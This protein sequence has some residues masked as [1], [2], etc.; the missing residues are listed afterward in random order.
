MQKFYLDPNIQEVKSYVGESVIFL[1][2]TA[3]AWYSN[4]YDNIIYHANDFNASYLYE[5][6]FYNGYLKFI[7]NNPNF[8][9]SIVAHN[10]RPLDPYLISR[11][12]SIFGNDS[13]IIRIFQRDLYPAYSTT[14]LKPIISNSKEWL[15]LVNETNLATPSEDQF[16]YF[17]IS[18]S[19]SAGI[20]EHDYEPGS[21][22]SYLGSPTS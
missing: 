7:P 13:A 11:V 14:F 20:T 12:I 9:V 15:F 5:P 1:N 21:P 8:A 18:V 3:Y 16:P 6:I 2:V 10:P 19:G 22:P 17:T 4:T